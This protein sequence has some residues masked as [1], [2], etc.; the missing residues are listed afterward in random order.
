LM[1]GA[2]TRRTYLPYLTYF[3]L[4]RRSGGATH[5]ARPA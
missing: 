1:P 4:Q 2:T 5:L 3:I